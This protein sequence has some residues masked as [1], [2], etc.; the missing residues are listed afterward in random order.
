MTSC[1]ILSTAQQHTA[2]TL[3]IHDALTAINRLSYNN[4]H[5][6]ISNWRFTYQ[7]LQSYEINGTY[8]LM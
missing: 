2:H 4:S 6:L 8:L 7:N 1:D 3:E 5:D